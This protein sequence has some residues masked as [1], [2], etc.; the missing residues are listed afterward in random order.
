MA[1][2]G[3]FSWPNPKG[4]LLGDLYSV[5]GSVELDARHVILQQ[6]N[7]ISTILL[8]LLAAWAKMCLALLPTLVPVPVLSTVLQKLS[9]AGDEYTSA[10]SS[11]F[12]R[13]TKS[14]LGSRSNL[15]VSATPIGRAL[16]QVLALVNDVPASSNK[17]VFLQGLADRVIQENR[18]EGARYNSINQAALKSS[19]TR[20]IYLLGLSLESR[21]QSDSFLGRLAK[22]L[23]GGAAVPSVIFSG[24][25]AKLWS[26]FGQLLS[27]LGFFSSRSNL[28]ESALQVANL[29]DADVAEKFAIELLWIAEKLLDCGGMEVA[30]QQWSSVSYLA[31]LSLRASPKVQKSLV[32]LSTLLCKG[33]VGNMSIPQEVC[34]KLMLLWL[35]LLCNATHGGDGPIFNS[36]E[37]GEAER[38]LELLV[39]SLP[40]TDQ[41][42]ILSTW[43]QEYAMS[44][45]DWPNLQNCYNTWCYTT[46]KLEHD[47]SNIMKLE[48]L[49]Y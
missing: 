12:G 14:H 26:F 11:S 4:G 30:V 28:N 3:E 23:P 22:N 40:E 38:Q 34:F 8:W 45:S 15:A 6:F 33:L 48:H 43:L 44:Q 35:P 17:Y 47:T 41:E 27:P 20:T 18:M 16:T 13:Q 32:R 19:F 21:R 9:T 24:P 1:E 49:K 39:A 46:R 10:L 25:F 7:T 2:L 5:Y 37:K 29:V 36:A 42:Q 31:E